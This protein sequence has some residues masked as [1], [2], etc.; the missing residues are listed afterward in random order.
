M[1]LVEQG[2]VSLDDEVSKHLPS[3]ATPRVVTDFN[4]A[5]GSHS[6]RPASRAITIRDILTN[7]SGLGY[8]FSNPTLA[9]LADGTLLTELDLPLVQDPGTKWTYSPGTRVAGWVV[10]ALTGQSLDAHFRQDIFEPLGM[11]DT[12]Y[13][14]P[15]EKL[16]RLVT[17][18]RREDST[19]AEVPNPTEALSPPNG[20]GGLFSTAHDYGLFMRMLLNGGSLNGVQ[21][22]RP[23]TVAL[24]GENHIGDLFVETQEP[25]LPMTLAF[26]L[27]AGR[28]KFGLGFQITADDERYAGF[29]APGS[30]SWAGAHNTHFWIDPSRGIA[31][32]VMMQLLP[33]Y[34]D[35]AI[36]T[37]RAFE[38][39]LYALLGPG[40]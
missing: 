17:L 22:L 4:P 27:G 15:T 13:A 9:R 10:E 5:D 1:R 34:D 38:E 33:F 6:T 24:M 23:E 3:Y 35:A 39:R 29:R 14:V 40:Q 28:D 25:G 12:D 37:L 32:A 21:I 31:A 18:H 26:P 36:A 19:L 7:T 11:Q 8:R 16:R 30:L 2:R 20:D